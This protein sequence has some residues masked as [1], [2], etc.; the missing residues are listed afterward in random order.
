M[1]HVRAYLGYVSQY[2]PVP[3]G[4]L[5]LQNFADPDYV[6]GY[7]G[8][9]IARGVSMHGV[10]KQISIHRKV[11][12]FLKSRIPADSEYARY[13]GRMRQWES[14]LEVQ[15]RAAMPPEPV[16]DLPEFQK[17][18]R[19]TQLLTTQAKEQVESDMMTMRKMTIE[20]AKLVSKG[21]VD[22]V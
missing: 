11:T 3:C 22:H 7:L 13:I 5:S 14:T 6:A 4:K 16:K 12:W 10:V 18:L 2:H 20:S 21:T 15:L 8:F 9:L 19:W 1:Q 17:V